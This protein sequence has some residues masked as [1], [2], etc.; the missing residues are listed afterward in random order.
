MANPASPYLDHLSHAQLL[1][2]LSTICNRDAAFR[3][4]LHAGL[5]TYLDKN[6]CSIQRLLNTDDGTSK[7]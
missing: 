4:T 5:H 6:N 1:E 7:T 3:H 2:A